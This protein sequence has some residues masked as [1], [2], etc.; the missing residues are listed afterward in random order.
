MSTLLHPAFGERTLEVTLRRG[1]YGCP[2]VTAHGD[3]DFSNRDQLAE[4]LAIPMGSS[5]PVVFLDLRPLAFMDSAGLYVIYRAHR[6]A[7]TRGTR[8]LIVRPKPSVFRLFS[9]RGLAT[10]FSFIATLPRGTV[11]R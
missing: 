6:D 3:V 11:H 7:Q 8:L 5:S 4:M 2:L 9:I 10:P 1:P